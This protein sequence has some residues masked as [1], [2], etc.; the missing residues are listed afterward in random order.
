MV[1]QIGAFGHDGYCREH[2]QQLCD[3]RYVHAIQAIDGFGAW[4]KNAFCA[5]SDV[6]SN[7]FGN[8]LAGAIATAQAEIEAKADFFAGVS[9]VILSGWGWGHSCSRWEGGRGG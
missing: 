6:G 7:A 3:G 5:D 1:G 4:P 9:F 8:A 2:I